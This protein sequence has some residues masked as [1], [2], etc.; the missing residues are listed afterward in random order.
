MVPIIILSSISLHLLL[1][2][3]GTGQ[4]KYF[5]SCQ[6][7]VSLSPTIQTSHEISFAILHNSNI[8]KTSLLEYCPGS[9]A[10]RTKWP[11]TVGTHSDTQMMRNQ[12]AAFHIYHILDHQHQPDTCTFLIQGHILLIRIPQDHM[13]RPH[14]QL[15]HCQNQAV[16]YN[17]VMQNQLTLWRREIFEKLLATQLLKKFSHSYKTQGSTAMVTKIQHWTLF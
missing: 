3:S 4:S 16:K 17:E 9:H 14:N 2:R 13:S 7:F 8:K 12:S 5:L 1:T 11:Q 15:S 10:V 6:C